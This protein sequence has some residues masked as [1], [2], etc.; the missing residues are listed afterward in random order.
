MAS[1]SDSDDPVEEPELPVEK[2][3]FVLVTTPSFVSPVSYIQTIDD[4]DVA[5]I[6]NSNAREYLTA[7]FYQYKDM[8]Y[9][10]NYTDKFVTRFLIDDNNELVED[11]KID[12]GGTTGRIWFQDDQ[13]AYTYENTGF[14]LK[15]FDPSDMIITKT[16]DLSML[17]RDDAPFMELYDVIERDNKLFI[18]LLLSTYPHSAALDSVHIAVLSLPSGSL[19]KI[20]KTGITQSVGA[21]IHSRICMMWC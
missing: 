10:C 6:D 7:G 20:I 17:K 14:Q 8:F 9:S 19:D 1:C 13:T 16:I 21:G 15:V 3:T 18:P 11:V 12:L 4:L 2:E 5:S